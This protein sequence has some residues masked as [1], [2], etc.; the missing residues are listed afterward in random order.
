MEAGQ[1]DV[2]ALAKGLNLV[3]GALAPR[4]RGTKR[5]SP[6]RRTSRNAPGTLFRTARLDAR[7]TSHASTRV[8]GGPPLFVT[9]IAR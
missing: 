6:R 5:S 4:R 8:E 1:V 3:V 9:S 7:R 2:P